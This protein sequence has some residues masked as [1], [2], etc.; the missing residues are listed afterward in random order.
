[1]TRLVLLLLLILPSAHLQAQNTDSTQSNV[2]FILKNGQTITGRILSLKKQNYLIKTQTTDTLMISMDQVRSVSV[3]G[4]S[5]SGYFEP[6][7]PFK[8]FLFNSAIPLQRK[9]WYYTNQYVFFN[10]I[11]YGISKNWSTGIA[12][13][14][15]NPP[16]FISPKIR[17]TFNP[18][19]RLK[20]G[21]GVQY[22]MIRVYETG[23]GNVFYH[24]GLAQA[25]ATY[26][27]SQNNFTLGAGKFIS[28]DGVYKGYVV[29]IAVTKK[30]SQHISFISENNF[31]VGSLNFSENG[32]GLLSGGI[33]IHAKKH[34]FEM[35]AFTP[36]VIQGGNIDRTIALPFA[37]YNLK[38]GK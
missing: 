2:V 33:R 4:L 7:F 38:L 31:V 36:A 11:N 28:P 8:Y 23:A 29:L 10:S 5:G 34:A 25:L 13:L 19:S 22:F 35:G 21:L 27:N 15:F 9:T 37:G 24:Y 32:F 14:S 17:Y 3:V 6:L 30:I 18:E 20:I 26:G 1:M 16:T 12:F